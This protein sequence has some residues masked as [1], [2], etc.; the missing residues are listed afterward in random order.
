MEDNRNMKYLFSWGSRQKP[1]ERWSRDPVGEGRE[2]SQTF[3]QCE[4][5]TQKFLFNSSPWSSLTTFNRLLT[6]PHQFLLLNGPNSL[7][8]PLLPHKATKKLEKS[9]TKTTVETDK[10]SNKYND[11]NPRKI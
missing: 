5:G 9:I 3:L 2:K 4:L 10:I 11:K 8:P 6:L 7:P 1:Q